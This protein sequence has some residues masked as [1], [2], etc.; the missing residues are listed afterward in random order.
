MVWFFSWR[1]L[2]SVTKVLGFFPD[3]GAVEVV[4]AMSVDAFLTKVGLRMTSRLHTSTAF[5]GRMDLARGQVFS[6][7][8]DFPKDQLEI[9]D[10]Q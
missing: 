1:F 9:L 6:L 7:N 5:Q 4:A 8:F 3:S 2:S 10:F